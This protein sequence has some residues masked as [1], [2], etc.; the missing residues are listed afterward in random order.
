MTNIDVALMERR[1][2]GF[3]VQMTKYVIVAKY[4][5]NDVMMLKINEF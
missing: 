5:V 1:R 4:V 2:R 3:D